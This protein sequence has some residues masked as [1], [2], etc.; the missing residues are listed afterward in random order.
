MTATEARMITYTNTDAG[1]VGMFRSICPMLNPPSAGLAWASR[2]TIDIVESSMNG[3]QRRVLV[4]PAL[5]IEDLDYARPSWPGF[6][7]SVPSEVRGC[8]RA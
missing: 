2:E 6:L 8:G 7:I 5:G 3:S 4:V 1:S